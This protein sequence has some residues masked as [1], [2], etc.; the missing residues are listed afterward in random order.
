MKG[1]SP[2]QAEPFQI[3]QTGARNTTNSR[4]QKTKKKRNRDHGFFPSFFF[5]FFL[6]FL[7]MTNS[8]QFSR[9]LVDFLNHTSFVFQAG[10]R[11]LKKTQP[12]PQHPLV[13][14]GVPCMG[15]WFFFRMKIASSLAVTLA[16]VVTFFLHRWV[17]CLS[18]AGNS[19]KLFLFRF[20]FFFLQVSVWASQVEPKLFHSALLFLGRESA[21]LLK[22]HTQ[23][24]A[25]F[26]E[27][28]QQ[29]PE[30]NKAHSL[31]PSQSTLHTAF[32]A[33]FFYIYTPPYRIPTTT[34]N[35]LLR[36]DATHLC[37]CLDWRRMGYSRSR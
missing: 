14:R 34:K 24:Y 9:F 31:S 17:I 35:K 11:N 32:F 5:L 33:A 28:Q 18:S 27:Q 10:E 3:I 29:Q 23:K 2:S 36:F 4:H 26:S 16:I 13:A 15:G 6:S 25:P 30:K 7:M 20:L 8:V 1:L 19:S 21:P 37:F 12:H 22:S